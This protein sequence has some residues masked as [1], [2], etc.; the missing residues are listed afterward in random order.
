MPFH[1]HLTLSIAMKNS[2]FDNYVL[3]ILGGSLG[4]C[5]ILMCGISLF[6]QWRQELDFEQRPIHGRL[7]LLK[8]IGRG[9]YLLTIE[10]ENGDTL[11]YDL[12]ISWFIEENNIQPND[13]ISKGSNSY[14]TRF[15]K[16]QS[17]KYLSCCVYGI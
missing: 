11:T 15:Y 14:A 10:Q 5:L 1:S 2:A 12:P 4:L 9:D 13:S 17:G 3:W 7:K 6:R 8:D 16:K